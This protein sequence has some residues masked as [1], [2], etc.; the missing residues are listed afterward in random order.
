MQAV[1]VHLVRLMHLV[2]VDH[3]GVV[4]AGHRDHVR[5]QRRSGVRAMRTT[6]A[7]LDQDRGFH[8][9]GGRCRAGR[10][11]LRFDDNGL[12]DMML[13]FVFVFVVFLVF[14][15]FV[16]FV[17]FI[18]FM[19]FVVF[20]FVVFVFVMMLVFVLDLFNLWLSFSL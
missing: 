13:S 2:H 17:M 12:Y 15:V 9:G 14:L 1:D 5:R 16:L 6:L 20:V 8:L 4:P 7:W 3:A 11:C 19:M 10:L 18:M